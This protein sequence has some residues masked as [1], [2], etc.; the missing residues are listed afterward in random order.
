MYI[1]IYRYTRS[2]G[3]IKWR[4][5]WF[6]GNTFIIWCLFQLSPVKVGCWIVPSYKRIL[7]KIDEISSKNWR[8]PWC[9]HVL[10]SVATKK[11]QGFKESYQLASSVQ[12]NIAIG[13]QSQVM[14][15][16][17]STLLLQSGGA[18]T[19]IQI[20]SSL[21]FPKRWSLKLQMSRGHPH[22]SK[23]NAVR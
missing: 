13:N 4:N 14:I 6:S 10:A 15:Y 8:S 23:T 2:N 21:C 20:G 17:A 16:Q 7:S 19:S 22:A 11:L 18:A 12:R 5:T 1:E 3:E 9:V